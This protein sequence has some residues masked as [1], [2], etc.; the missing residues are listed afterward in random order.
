MND[1]FKKTEVKKEWP[2]YISCFLG[3]L[4]HY[5]TLPFDLI[6]P[7]SFMWTPRP[8]SEMTT[9]ITQRSH[10]IRKASLHH[11]LQNIKSSASQYSISCKTY[12]FHYFLDQ[13]F[14]S[15]K[16]IGS[17]AYIRGQP[18]NPRKAEP[19]LLVLMAQVNAH[20]RGLLWN[21][22]AIIQSLSEQKQKENLTQEDISWCVWYLLTVLWNRWVR[23]SE[24]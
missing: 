12:C 21:V 7:C 20:E 3:D 17:L 22:L 10:E 8:G 23:C 14:F 13:Q 9:T 5:F 1:Y 2:C 4:N 19:I 11:F 16:C 18:A 15:P 6:I 24:K